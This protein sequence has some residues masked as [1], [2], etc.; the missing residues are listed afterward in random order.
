MP[1]LNLPGPF[2][3]IKVTASDAPN[4]GTLLTIIHA[5]S[6][7]YAAVY[8]VNLDSTFAY[9]GRSESL[10]KDDSAQA[11]AYTNGTVRLYVSEA[12]PGQSGT[13]SKVHYY[14]FPNAV[15]PEV[16]NN[17]VDQYAR[18]QITTVK[19]RLVSAGS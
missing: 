9:I 13:T 19:A 14:D 12:D 2:P 3:H 10:G 7:P 11:K 17:T 1:I 4:N 15:A 6:V 5:S 18:D 16:P 8:L